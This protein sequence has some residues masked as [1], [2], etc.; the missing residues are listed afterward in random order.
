MK[1]WDSPELEA[2]GAE[3]LQPG[4]AEDAAPHRIGAQCG[5]EAQI[6]GTGELG[7][8]GDQ[9]RNRLGEEGAR[10]PAR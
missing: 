4:N 1:A 3:R 8:L 2:G 6:S 10:Q 7:G 5:D 9:L